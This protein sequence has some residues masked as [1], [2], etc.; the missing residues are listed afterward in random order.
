MSGGAVPAR[1]FDPGPSSGTIDEVMSSFRAQEAH[2]ALPEA[3]WVA[4][5]TIA[6]DGSP[7]IGREHPAPEV[8][9]EHETYL[10]ASSACRDRIVDARRRGS[11]AYYRAVAARGPERE[12]AL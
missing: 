11:K 9:S 6:A 3:G 4:V 7:M 8:V 10:A 1:F 2:N 5:R 12:F